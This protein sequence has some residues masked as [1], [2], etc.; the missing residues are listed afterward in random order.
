MIVTSLLDSLPPL[1]NVGLFLLFIIILFGTF[2]LHMFTGMFE[3]RC[4]ITPQPVNGE[5]PVAPEHYFLCKSDDQCPEGT[6]C[7][8]P[9]NIKTADGKL[10]EW[11]VE[12]EVRDIYEFNYYYCNFDNIWESMLTIF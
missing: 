4:R 9:L 11:K 6:Y 7:G 12:E 5:W 10:M 2:G 1:A 3:Y 8:A